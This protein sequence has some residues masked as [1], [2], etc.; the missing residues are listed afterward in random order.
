MAAPLISTPL[1]RIVV[2]WS[3]TYCPSGR[4][5]MA[6]PPTAVHFSRVSCLRMGA[7]HMAPVGQFACVPQ[8]N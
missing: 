4:V 6:V 7:P 1:T 8:T 2:L 3:S 5:R